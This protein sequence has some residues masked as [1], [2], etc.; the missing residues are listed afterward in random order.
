[1][2]TLSKKLFSLATALT[3]ASAAAPLAFAQG[4]VSIIRDI[5]EAVFAPPGFD[6][7]DHAQVVL[8]GSFINTCFKVGPTKAE[9]EHE[10]RTIHVTQQAYVLDTPWCL[11]VMIPYTSVVDV[12]ML[13]AG[14]YSV[15]IR[16]DQAKEKEFG[17]MPISRA[18]ETPGESPNSPDEKF[19]AIVDDFSYENGTV[20]LKGKLPGDCVKL[21]EIQILARK[22]NIVEVLPVAEVT[23]PGATSCVQNLVPF[24]RQVPFKSPWKGQTLF[25]VRSLNGQAI[26]KVIE[27]K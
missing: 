15:K 3:V 12:G 25:H 1:M 8:S 2:K 16:T 18:R 20:T 9:V 4:G 19:Y 24:E 17:L 5:P 6:S 27:I 23:H 7:N 26:N 13:P 22:A 21:K 14:N 11:Q 10:T